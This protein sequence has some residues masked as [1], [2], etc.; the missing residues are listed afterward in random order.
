MIMTLLT[1]K[2]LIIFDCDGVLIDSREANIK[3]FN[4]CLKQGGYPPLRN[5]SAEKVAYLSTRQLM[6]ELIQ[7]PAEAE[8][9]FRISQETDYTPFIKDIHVKCIEYFG[10]EK[11]EA[12]YLGD[13][14]SDRDAAS[15]AGIDSL[16]VG[17]THESGIKSAGDL[18]KSCS[19]IT[20]SYPR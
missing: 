15:N 8:R 1:D 13:S 17:G 2:R 10:I 19:I 16:W 9:L 5:E 6:F 18:L 11:S 12:L 3:F 4:H 7:D 20:N 14:E